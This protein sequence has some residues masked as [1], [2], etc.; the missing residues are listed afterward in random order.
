[1]GWVGSL[2]LVEYRAPYGANKQNQ[3]CWLII[4]ALLAP[5]TDQA[6]TKNCL[7][8]LERCELLAQN[9][10]RPVQWRAVCSRRACTL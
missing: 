2:G 1:M 7:S 6:A 8:E 4:A 3:I 9:L 5:R 10:P